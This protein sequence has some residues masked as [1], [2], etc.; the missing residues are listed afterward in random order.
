MADRG[1]AT[2]VGSLSERP[3]GVS[4]SDVTERGW[5]TARTVRSIDQFHSVR[6]RRSSPDSALDLGRGGTYVV[7]QIASS[8]W[9]THVWAGEALPR[10]T[11]V[12][13]AR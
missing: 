10:R 2:Q 6:R 11:T 7:Q 3:P 13:C 5:V 12:R 8:V 9:I 1:E 4:G